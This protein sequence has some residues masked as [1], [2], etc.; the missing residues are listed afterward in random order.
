[1]LRLEAEAL[2]PLVELRHTDRDNTA[3]GELTGDLALQVAGSAL[4]RDEAGRFIEDETAALK[5]YAEDIDIPYSTLRKYRATGA[6]WPE[7]VR[8]RAG[9][10]GVC[11]RLASLPLREAADD[12]W[13][14]PAGANRLPIISCVRPDTG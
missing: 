14:P 10:F 12:P 7:G 9:C 3:R 8:T 6:A 1:L 2:N 4:P 13:H 11:Q 5:R